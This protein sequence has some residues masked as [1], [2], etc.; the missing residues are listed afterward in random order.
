MV[1][2]S[3][4]GAP[5]QLLVLTARHHVRTRVKDGYATDQTTVTPQPG[6]SQQLLITLQTEAEARVAAIPQAII[7]STEQTL[8]LILPDRLK[9]G[10]GRRERGR[11]SNET[12]KDILLTKAYYLDINEVTNKHFK[13]FDPNHGS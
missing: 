8:K 2:G 7:T 5:S 4:A 3:A 9:M 12:E 13:S 1:D 11:R 6:L 10:A